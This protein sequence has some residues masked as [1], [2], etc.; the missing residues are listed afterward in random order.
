MQAAL[1]FLT[2][3]PLRSLR[4]P[5]R[6]SL[7]SFPFVGM[8]IGSMWVAAAWSVS[9]WWGPWVAAVSVLMVDLVVTGGLHSDAV[10]DVA[11]GLA[12]R[13]PVDEATIVMRDPAIGAVGAAVLICVLLM[14]AGLVT[15]VVAGG[16]WWSL[17][18]VPVV[19]RAA[20]VWVL[21][22]ARSVPASSIA[23]SLAQAAGPREIAVVAV[24]TEAMA[25]VTLDLRIISGV[26]VGLAAAEAWTHLFERR[27][28]WI[29]GDA[30]GVAGVLSETL[31]LA[32]VSLA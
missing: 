8:L 13:K 27:F 19:G 22:R 7:L 30:V 14:R 31:A 26:L 21:G 32:L 1:S 9:R 15:S 18:M 23:S 25:A 10:G 12:S 5:G 17:L 6:S 28:G 11:D 3:V 4:L 24:T 29:T 20:M 16:R 2:T